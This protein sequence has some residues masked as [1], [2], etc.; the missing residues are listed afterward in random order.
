MCTTDFCPPQWGL[1]DKN[2][3][4]QQQTA[5]KTT[6]AFTISD[7]QPA[8]VNAARVREISRIEHEANRQ[9]TQ[10]Q[11]SDYEPNTLNPNVCGP[12]W[13]GLVGLMLCLKRG[14]GNHSKDPGP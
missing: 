12:R 2:K 7:I 4:Q 6:V 3:H 11:P 13:K 5:A 10:Q 14:P 9:Y 1:K 8:A